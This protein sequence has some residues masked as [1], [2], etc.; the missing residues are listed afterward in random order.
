MRLRGPR[1]LASQLILLLV[2]AVVAA[3]GPV[4][5]LFAFKSTRVGRA[6][7]ATHVGERVAV[8]V[9]VLEVTPADLVP[10][11]LAAYSIPASGVSIDAEVRVADGPRQADNES[12]ARLIARRLRITNDRVRVQL[13]D[14]TEALVRYV[15]WRATP[16][17]LLVSVDLAP[18]RWLNAR[19]RVVQPDAPIWLQIGLVQFGAAIVAILVTLG[20]GLRH[21]VRPV[22]ALADAAEQFGLGVAVVPLPERGPRELR[23]MT[24]SFNAM[25]ARLRAFVSDRTRMLGAISHDLRTPL[26]SLWLR[27]EM[28]EDDDLREAMVRT[29]AEMKDMVEATL[30]FARDDA[31]KQNGDVDLAE[32][33]RQIA[34]DHR[35]LGRDVAFSGPATVPFQGR[36]PALRRALD[37][38]V[39][40]AVR[41]GERA[42]VT[43]IREPAAVQIRIE[44]DGPGLPPD[45]IQDMFEPFVRLDDSRN[46]QTGGTGLGLAIA[47]SAIREHGGDVTLLNLPVRGLR[48]EV[49]LPV[50][51]GPSIGHEPGVDPELLREADAGAPTVVSG[52]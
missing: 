19:S 30:A 47:R 4:S 22:T 7:F 31:A 41:Y 32:L 21:V 51:G 18:G 40:N 1:S 38:L 23:T 44:D 52:R 27:A 6:A 34:D 49:V 42:R 24:A 37:N 35:V 36:A 20:L 14:D 33:A 2:L 26:S 17:T 39:E 11:I 28:V 50:G 48:A 13:I 25:Q 12:I 15:P 29:L 9:H 46:A 5:A 45:R 8:L 10:K 16:K 3:Q 43:L